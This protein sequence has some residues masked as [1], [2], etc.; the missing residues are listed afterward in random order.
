MTTPSF[1]KGEGKPNFVPTAPSENQV[2]VN[3]AMDPNKLVGYVPS[4][5]G[6]AF[7]IYNYLNSARQW[8]NIAGG[9]T[10]QNVMLLLGKLTGKAS[11]IISMINHKFNWDLIESSLKFECGDNRA[12]NT[13]LLELTN[14][15]KKGTYK[16]LIFE[17]KQ[18]LFF[19]RCKLMDQYKSERIV[20]EIMEPYINTAQNTLQNSLP[21]HDQIFVSDCSF[22]DTV[23]KILQLEA[24][25]R[26]DNIKQ[27][28]SN[29]FPSPRVITQQPPIQYA[30]PQEMPHSSRSQMLN[31]EQYPIKVNNAPYH[32]RYP[33]TPNP[34]NVFMRPRHHYFNGNG[35]HQF[36]DNKNYHR[37]YKPEDVTMRTAPPP[38]RHGQVNLG[39]GF[40]AEEVFYHP[41]DMQD[42]QDTHYGSTE[43][44]YPSEYLEYTPDYYQEYYRYYDDLPPQRNED[45]RNPNVSQEQQDF[46]ETLN[47]KEKS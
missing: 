28:F 27:K 9:T 21:Y 14:V 23:A 40:V 22:N 4:Y 13:L 45:F 6:D 32:S 11:L 16:E 12:F 3:S 38:L 34:N 19:I 15:K 5:D 7:T 10:P 36:S 18:K 30:I 8:L 31:N 44:N 26:F 46:R 37:Q 29:L 1:N 42:M 25:G 20:E 35:R 43:Q 33:W 2:P 41:E 39:K 17:L 47:S 24:G